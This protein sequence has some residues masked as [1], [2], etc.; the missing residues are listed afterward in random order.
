MDHQEASPEDAVL[1]QAV[2]VVRNAI[3]AEDYQAVWPLLSQVAQD[4]A[5]ALQRGRVML[6]SAAK[7]NARML[8][9]YDQTL[10]GQSS[11]QY[12]AIIQPLTM[13]PS[14]RRRPS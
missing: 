5:G 14:P 4:S 8:A 13:P 7:V 2:G 9:I 6:Q 1:A 12:Q 11:W 3:G 10:R